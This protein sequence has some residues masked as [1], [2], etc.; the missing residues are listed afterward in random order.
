MSAMC[1]PM[2]SRVGFEPTAFHCAGDCTSACASRSYMEPANRLHY[3]VTRSGTTNEAVRLMGRPELNRPSVG[4]GKY[5]Q[6]QTQLSCREAQPAPGPNWDAA[7]YATRLRGI[8]SALRSFFFS[9]GGEL[10]VYAIV[11][12]QDLC[13]DFQK[14]SMLR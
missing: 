14:R 9:L 4:E 2:E 12:G 3:S 7:Y 13:P 1:K 6:N 8:R 5:G 10:D 11:V